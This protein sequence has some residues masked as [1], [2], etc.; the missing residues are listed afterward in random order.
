MRTH[1]P[2]ENIEI[3]EVIDDDDLAF[4][5]QA[6]ADTARHTSKN[7]RWTGPVAAAVLVAVVGFGV[8]TSATDSSVRIPSTPGLIDAEYYVADPPAGFVMYLAEARGEGGASEAHFA[9][10]GSSQAQLWATP[11]ASSTSGSWFVVSRGAQYTTGRNAYRQLVDGI[12]VTFERDPDSRQVR[13][14]FTKNGHEMGITALGWL[15][16]QL[17]RLVRSVNLDNS[18]IGFS[19]GFFTTDHRRVLQTDP[20]SALFGVPVT[21]VGYTTGLPTELAES[22]TITVAGEGT[23]DRADVLRFA[24]SNI[25]PFDNG[26]VPGIIGQSAADQRVM[27]AQWLDGDRLITISGKLDIRRLVAIAQSVHQSPARRTCIGSSKRAHR[28]SSRHCRSS[29][30]RSC[31]AC[32]PTGGV[33]RSRS[34]SGTLP[35]L[36]LGTCGGSANRATRRSRARHDRAL[37]GGEPAIDTFVE[38]GRTYVLASVPRLHVRRRAACQPHRPAIDHHTAA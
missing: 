16:R 21:R 28:R 19:D 3:I 7:S 18:V 5:Q 33:G 37:P 29:R 9:D 17:V 20:A 32:S 4:P 12:E 1:A 23:A 30:G 10:P 11:D 27:I 6:S 26:D 31:P 15:D 25:S 13:L 38:H 24:L 22:F 34:P 14:T 35:I 2:L 36:V 8:V